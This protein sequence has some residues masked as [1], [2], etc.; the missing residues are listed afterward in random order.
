M[1]L[2]FQ[3]NRYRTILTLVITNTMALQL[4]LS[5]CCMIWVILS[6]YTI[7]MLPQSF[8]PLTVQIM[9][10][11]TF[12]YYHHGCYHLF[13]LKSWLFSSFSCYS[14]LFISPFHVNIMVIIIFSCYHHSCYHLFML[15]SWLFSSFSCYSHLFHP[16]LKSA[17]PPFKW[18]L[19][20][21]TGA[22]LP[23]INLFPELFSRITLGWP[24]NWRQA[25]FGF[26]ESD[27][28]PLIT[29]LLLVGEYT[30][31]SIYI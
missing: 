23:F 31:S 21:N 2:S 24:T 18:I 5:S 8:H 29:S 22:E 9:I 20:M 6:C 17:L 12:S 26:W 27:S 30:L 4:C 10:I 28:R 13:M 3:L 19:Y 15:K 16:E 25:K 11:I 14:H 1:N 7:M